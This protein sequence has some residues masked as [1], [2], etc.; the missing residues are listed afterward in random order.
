MLLALVVGSGLRTTMLCNELRAILYDPVWF[1]ELITLLLNTALKY[2]AIM[3]RI[4]HFEVP[5]DDPNRAQDFY[6]HT[7]GWK[8]DKWDGPME[9][10]MI[11]TGEE[12]SAGINGGLSK[13][14][15]GHSGMTNVIDVPSVDEYCQKIQTNG[16]QILEGK[17]PIQGVGYFASCKDT[18]GNKFAIIEMDKNAK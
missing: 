15:P 18:E 3:P 11:K 17:M 7:F 9:Y 4:V 12:G 8:F 16:G 1:L 6:K 13:R 5:A 2:H 10:W 14:M